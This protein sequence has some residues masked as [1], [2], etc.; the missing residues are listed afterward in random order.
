MSSEVLK[1]REELERE[2]QDQI[3]FLRKSSNEYDKG[4]KREAKRI[5]TTLYILLHEGAQNRSL[6]KKLGLRTKL[7]LH[8]TALNGPPDGSVLPKGLTGNWM[9]VAPPLTVLVARG[10]EQFAFEPH[11]SLS[12]DMEPW[13]K[14]LRFN[15]WWEE[16]V[17]SIGRRPLSR[18]GLVHFVRSQDGGAHADIKRKGESY[19]EFVEN[20]A[21]DGITFGSGGKNYTPLGANLATIRQI[22]WEVDKALTDIGY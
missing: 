9:G 3:Y 14:R 7:P 12:N 4:E 16:S 22:A 20:A 2:L 19:I 13:F 15:E 5:A 10:G 17:S 6:L 18:K 8:S 1:T 11:C 21:P